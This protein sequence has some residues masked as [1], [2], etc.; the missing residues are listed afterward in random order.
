MQHTRWV[1]G[2]SDAE[3][4]TPFADAGTFADASSA[5]NWVEAY[6]RSHPGLFRGDASR[7]FTCKRVPADNMQA[8]QAM[9]EDPCSPAWAWAARVPSAP[10]AGDRLIRHELRAFAEP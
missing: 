5:L 7:G 9:S 1:V 2:V 4:W 8:V 6:L 10:P 3:S